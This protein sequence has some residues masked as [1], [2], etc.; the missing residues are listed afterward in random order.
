MERRFLVYRTRNGKVCAEIQYGL[1]QTGEGVKKDESEVKRIELLDHNLTL[2]QAME[3][4][5][6]EKTTVD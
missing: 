1:H 2:N 6:Y 3:M 4:Y 5:P